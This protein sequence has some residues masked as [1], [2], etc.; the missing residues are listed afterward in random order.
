[1]IR[2]CLVLSWVLLLTVLMCATIARA[3]DPTVCIM[4][5]EA[6][7]M[8]VIRITGGGALSITNTS[9]SRINGVVTKDNYYFSHGLNFF[10]SVGPRAIWD[11]GGTAGQR[12]S[13]VVNSGGQTLV[14]QDVVGVQQPISWSNRQHGTAISSMYA[15]AWGFGSGHYRFTLE[16][17]SGVTCTPVNPIGAQAV[18]LDQTDF[19][20]SGADLR[21]GGNIYLYEVGAAANTKASFATSRQFFAGYIQ[22]GFAFP[23]AGNHGPRLRYRFPSGKTGVLTNGDNMPVFQGPGLYSFDLDYSLA[24]LQEVLIDGWAF[25]LPT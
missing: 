9:Q 25:D 21:N 4:E 22:T 20:S 5:G 15:A 13:I 14:A 17:S 19:R 2:R 16:M 24:P 7:G 6:P 10:D 3:A 18:H 11:I 12:P 8:S 1:M 23:Q